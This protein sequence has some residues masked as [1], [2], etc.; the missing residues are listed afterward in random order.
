MENETKRCP[1]RKRDDGE[2]MLCYGNKCMAYYSEPYID[3]SPC[4]GK[5]TYY[6]DSCKMLQK[7]GDKTW[8]NT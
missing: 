8:T 5:E 3:R 2:Y 4:G 7:N 6:K 1:F